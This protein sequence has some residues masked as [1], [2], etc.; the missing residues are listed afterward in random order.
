MA[1]EEFVLYWHRRGNDRAGLA[2]V[3]AARERATAT[4]TLAGRPVAHGVELDLK[5]TADGL[6]Y[7]HHG[8]TGRERLSPVEVRRRAAAGDGAALIDDL[9]DHDAARDLRYLVELKRGDG[10]PGPAIEAFARAVEARGLSA[11]AWL[12]SSSL[13]LLRH[14]AERAPALPRVLFADPPGQ[15]GVVPHRPTVYIRESLRAFG[16]STRLPPGLV[17]HVCAIGLLA[18]GADVHARRAAEARAH[19]LGYLPGRVS[20]PDVAAAL[21]AQGAPG[22]FMYSAPAPLGA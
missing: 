7:A 8:P 5:W 6:L 9:L 10:D 20:A 15:D 2:A 19:G 13:L 1:A 3:H 16:A 11:R 14:A 22:A 18:R 21:A 12:A 4:Q 17:T